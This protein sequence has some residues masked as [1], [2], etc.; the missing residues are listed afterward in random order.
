[1]S[2]FTR[3]EYTSQEGAILGGWV[4]CRKGLRGVGDGEKAGGGKGGL[5]EAEGVKYNSSNTYKTL[6]ISHVGAYTHTACPSPLHN[7]GVQWHLQFPHCQP[8]STDKRDSQ[9]SPATSVEVALPTVTTAGV[10]GEVTAATLVTTGVRTDTTGEVAFTTAPVNGSVTG[11]VALTT[12][13]TTA[14]TGEVVLT[15]PPTTG[16]TA[17]VTGEVTGASAP[18]TGEVTPATTPPTA[19]RR[20]GGGGGE[21]SDEGEGDA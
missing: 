11:V 3:H 2:T 14:V 1:M 21:G 9:L 5:E 8:R 17:L 18:A 20:V 19:P 12:G 4:S 10:T 15:T 13:A 7:S 16:V 6:L